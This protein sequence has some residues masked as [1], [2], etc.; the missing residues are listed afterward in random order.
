MTE[1]IFQALFI[2]TLLAEIETLTNVCLQCSSI[3]CQQMCMGTLHYL[4]Q[5]QDL[6]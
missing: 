3:I 2:P 5:D 1:I 6:N 4:N